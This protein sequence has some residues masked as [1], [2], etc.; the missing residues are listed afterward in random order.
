[1]HTMARVP[2]TRSGST[3][4]LPAGGRGFTLIELLVVIAIIGIL[5]SIVLAATG[6]SRKKGRD[7]RRLADFKQIQLA[8]EL[9]FDAAASPTYPAVASGNWGTLK[10][11][12][13]SHISLP[14]DPI[15]DGTNYFYD[16]QSTNGASTPNPCNSA[17]CVGY[18]LQAKMETAGF[19]SGITGLKAGLAC[20]PG[21]AAPY[22][23][24][25]MQ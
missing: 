1:M 11:A 12:L 17:P 7:A 2:K 14:S 25:A 19:V 5:A 8:L 13:V 21:A 3:K 10:T 18:V 16:Y 23:Y 15:N 6:T 20:T 4:S 24:C 9:Y 22:N